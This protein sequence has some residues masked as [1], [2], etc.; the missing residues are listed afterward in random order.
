MAP[1]HRSRDDAGAQLIQYGALI[2]L[3]AVLMG[4][5]TFMLAPS[6]M[7][8]PIGR[9]VCQMFTR[10][11]DF[12][13]CD[14]EFRPD[15]FYEPRRCMVTRDAEGTSHEVTVVVSGE[16]GTTFIRE[17]YS[18]GTVKV[19]A[20]DESA[21]RASFGIGADVDIGPI[22]QAGV[23]ADA[24]VEFG[25]PGSVTWE[26]DSA[27][28]ADRFQGD[29]EEAAKNEAGGGHFTDF[30]TWSDGDHGLP[31]PSSVGR[32]YE[33]G[34]SGEA[35]AGLSVGNS[36]DRKKNDDGGSGSGSGGGGENGEDQNDGDGGW[37]ADIGFEPGLEVGVGVDGAYGSEDHADGSTSKIYK[38]SGNANFG[39]DWAVD[40]VEPSGE[41]Q[42]ALKV[43]RDADGNVTEVVISQTTTVNGE[44]KV[45]TTQLPVDSAEQREVVENW[46]GA[47][48]GG[49]ALPI[50]WDAMI[51]DE[52]PDDPDPFT[53]LLYDEANVTRANYDQEIDEQSYGADVKFIVSLGYSYNTYSEDTDVNSAEYLGSPDGEGG[54]E[55]IEYEAC[56][57]G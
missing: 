12:S 27:D 51:P 39:A 54:R 46:L 1:H 10:D 9:A 43:T 20:V 7:T 8:V 34:L 52:L 25:W 40:S 31:E 35:H 45:V 26:F 14:P 11:G 23:G 13:H 29:I 44:V 55:F 42:G 17:E 48:P 19:I 28:E 49:N 5:L 47:V 3:A 36:G 37:S 57:G 30:E 50:T 32:D 56:T 16:D 18:D 15:E 53:R 24:G 2:V 22:F 21:L 33:G 38:L 41:R 6:V 4:A